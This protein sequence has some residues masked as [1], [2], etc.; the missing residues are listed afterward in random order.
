[1]FIICKYNKLLNT[2]QPVKIIHH[3]LQI[4]CDCAVCM[5]TAIYKITICKSKIYCKVLYELVILLTHFM[6]EYFN[7][8]TA[9][10]EILN[11]YTESI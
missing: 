6:K 7:P 2:I 5:R 4:K 9:E 3:L 11:F 8:L 10:N 1:M